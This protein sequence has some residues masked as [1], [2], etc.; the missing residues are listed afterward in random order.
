MA[1]NSYLSQTQNLLHDT[2]AQ[3]YTTSQLTTYINQARAKTAA[4]GQCCRFL[5]PSG[6]INTVANQ[7]TYTFAAINALLPAQLTSVLGVVTIAVNI[8]TSK[9]CLRRYSWSAFQAYLRSY[10]IGLTGYP[11]IFAQYGQGTPYTDVSTATSANTSVQIYLWPIPSAIYA[12]DWDCYCLPIA[13]VNDSTPEAIPYPFTD[14]VPYYACHLALMGAQRFADAEKM[15]SRFKMKIR[16][17]QSQS[18]MLFIPDF[19]GM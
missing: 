9:P 3:F 11:M 1:L 5:P 17:A 19:Y 15:E 10:S 7:E 16:E 2:N 13:L 14:A 8:G 4:A 12:M 6:T 18:D